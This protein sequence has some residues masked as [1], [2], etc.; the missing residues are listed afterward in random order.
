MVKPT[1]RSSNLSVKCSI[2]ANCS[3]W[4]EP[5]ESPPKIYNPSPPPLVQY[6]YQ[7]LIRGSYGE[8]HLEVVKLER[9]V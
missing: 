4:Q 7:F 2:S 6:L 8:T 3:V 9:E 5:I 1:L